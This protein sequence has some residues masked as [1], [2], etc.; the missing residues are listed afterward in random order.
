MVLFK[1]SFFPEASDHVGVSLSSGKFGV[2]GSE[3]CQRSKAPTGAL[4]VRLDREK[5]K[6]PEPVCRGKS[7]FWNQT[8]LSSQKYWG[9]KK[10]KPPFPVV[11][12]SLQGV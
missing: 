2:D 8:E 1:N 11:L 10:K 5:E 6:H 4:L 12:K 7:Q 3:R 9:E